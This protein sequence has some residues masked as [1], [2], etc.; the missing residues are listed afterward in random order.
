MS[1]RGK[2]GGLFDL[3]D[4]LPTVVALAIVGAA[5]AGFVASR[6]GDGAHVAEAAVGAF[7]GLLFGSLAVWRARRRR[8]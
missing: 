8:R 6:L 4:A 7:L 2:R 1:R 5:V 3:L